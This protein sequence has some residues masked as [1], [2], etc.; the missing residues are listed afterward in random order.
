MAKPDMSKMRG[1]KKGHKPP[2]RKWYPEDM[3]G[4]DEDKAD[5]ETVTLAYESIEHMTDKATL[6]IIEGDKVWVPKSQTLEATD[7]EVTVTLW[8]VEKQ[9]L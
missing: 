9:G 5:P 6:L 2:P 8:W 7:K 4:W 3:V 1:A